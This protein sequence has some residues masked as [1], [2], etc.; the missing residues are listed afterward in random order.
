MGAFTNTR[1]NGIKLIVLQVNNSE[2]FAIITLKPG[3]SVGSPFVGSVSLSQT[4]F[5]N[6]DA[7]LTITLAREHWNK[8]YGT[9][10]LRF[11]IDYGFKSLALHRISLAV[12]AT[13]PRATA[14]YTK[15]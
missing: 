15:L 4:S 5:K 13:N 6:R 3:S 11:V 10:V 7:T 14:V 1:S 2:L 8:G 12:F 9:E